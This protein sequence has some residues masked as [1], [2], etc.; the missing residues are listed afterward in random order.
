LLRVF[1]L[2]DDERTQPTAGNVFESRPAGNAEEGRW[3]GIP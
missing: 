1:A 3:H 2:A